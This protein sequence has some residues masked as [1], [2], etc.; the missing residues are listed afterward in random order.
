MRCVVS[1]RCESSKLWIRSVDV[2]IITLVGMF[3]SMSLQLKLYNN[4]IP[5]PIFCWCTFLCSE[6]YPYNYVDVQTLYEHILQSS[7]SLWVCL[8]QWN[9]SISKSV[10]NGHLWTSGCWGLRN[11]KYSAFCIRQGWWEGK[12]KKLLVCILCRLVYNDESSRDFES[13]DQSPTVLVRCK[14]GFVL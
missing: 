14:I 10:G 5:L 9:P 7:Q 2:C 8:Q 12:Q 4:Y 1:H 6:I 13:I 3:H 11:R